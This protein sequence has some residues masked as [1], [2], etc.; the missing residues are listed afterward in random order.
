LL[1]CALA[2]AG[3]GD[4]ATHSAS[5]QIDV[6]D[7]SSDHLQGG[8]TAQLT[9]R[10]NIAG[11]FVIV[12]SVAGVGAQGGADTVL[13][14][15][16]VAA[17]IATTTLIPASRLQLGRNDITI[18]VLPDSGQ[19]GA[20]LTLTITRTAPDTD[21]D[22]DGFSPAGGDCDDTDPT[23]HPGAP[24]IPYN[25]KDDD[26]DP[27]TPDDD[28]DRDGY[29][30]QTDCNDQDAR[31]HPGAVEVC[32][33]GIDQDC[34]GADLAC[35]AVDEV[36]VPAGPFTMGT[37][38]GTGDADEQPQH[39]VTLGEFHLDRTEVTNGS[40]R[41]CVEAHACTPPGATGSVSRAS[42]Y[43]DAGF[44]A[45]PVIYVSWQQA[46]A[47]CR[48]LGRRLPTEAEWEKAARGAAD[49]RQYPWGSEPPSC[50]QANVQLNATMIC[51]GDTVMVGSYPARE[52]SPYGAVDVCGNVWEW[53][54]D[55]YSATYYAQSPAANPSGP[56]SGAQRV[57]RGGS[58]LNDATF[59]RV[60]NRASDDPGAQLAAVGFRCAR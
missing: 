46:D 25:G 22:G 6:L 28:L 58:F 13:A 2:L 10:A 38:A 4:P 36:L 17:G 27:S 48:W 54:A 20:R 1:A 53:V 50:N 40:Y 60:A 3:C 31:I 5:P 11:E 23:V 21:A 45:Y 37:P 59:G 24:E 15:G 18:L 49:A 26:C 41:L 51:N 35:P 55:W 29:P 32:G 34:S 14:R 12:A 44:D 47:Y 9:W 57:R 33:D 43:G 19:P 42:Y 16:A 8:D 30:H 52:A 7:L 39:T 56:A